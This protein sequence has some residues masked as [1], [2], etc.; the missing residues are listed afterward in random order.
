MGGI[1]GGV[2]GGTPIGSASGVGSGSGEGMPGGRSGCG[3]SGGVGG[4]VG[5]GL[6]FGIGWVLLAYGLGIRSTLLV[7]QSRSARAQ[8][9]RAA[10]AARAPYW[11]RNCSALAA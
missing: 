3:V 2:A 1:S 8:R 6:G 5:A 4:R 11:R 7:L 9:L 10:A